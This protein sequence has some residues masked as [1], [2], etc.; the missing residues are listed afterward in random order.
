MTRT[1]KIWVSNIANWTGRIRG[2][3]GRKRLSGT[4]FSGLI[5]SIRRICQEKIE[6][7]THIKVSSE[8]NATR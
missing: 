8:L 6:Y 1:P 7:E 5:G 3:I 4:F 2:D